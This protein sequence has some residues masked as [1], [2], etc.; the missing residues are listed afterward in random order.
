MPRVNT[1][2]SLRPNFAATGNGEFYSFS[3]NTTSVNEGNTVLFTV[4]TRNVSESTLYW[5]IVAV[6][7]TFNSLD[8]DS[9]SGSFNLT[10]NVGSFPITL[11]EDSSTEGTEIFQL[12][13]RKNST[14]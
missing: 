7:G 13:L 11:L 1:L 10:S 14:S 5:T 4:S 3:A 2:I 9:L 12:Q 8:T 6:S